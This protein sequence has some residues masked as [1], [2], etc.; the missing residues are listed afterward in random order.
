[1]H[2]N[3][4]G[5]DNSVCTYGSIIEFKKDDYVKPISNVHALKILLVDTRVNRSTKALVE[6]L[7]ELKHR[8]PVIIDL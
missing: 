3:P 7:L 2:G 8:Y 6:R 1:M 5:I 4:S